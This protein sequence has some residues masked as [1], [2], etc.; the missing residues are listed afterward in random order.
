MTLDGRIG[1][2][3]VIVNGNSHGEDANSA[4]VTDLELQLIS[5]RIVNGAMMAAQSAECARVV[6]QLE[7]LLA[8]AVADRDRHQIP[9]DR[10]SSRQPFESCRQKGPS[11]KN[12]DRQ[13]ALPD[14]DKED[15]LSQA[16]ADRDK[17]DLLSQ[18]FADRDNSRQQAKELTQRLDIA[19]DSLV[20]LNAGLY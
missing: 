11:D 12:K 7:S 10:S 15:L 17:E 18:A 20:A 16:L 5:M 8:Q 19:L 3:D 2:N 1:V 13:Q 9:F 14:R 6:H 4:D